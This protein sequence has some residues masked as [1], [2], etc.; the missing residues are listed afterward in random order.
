MQPADVVRK[1]IRIWTRA[2]IATVAVVGTARPAAAQGTLRPGDAV[3]VTVLN[4]PELSG[5]FPVSQDGVVL[6]PLLGSVRVTGRPLDEVVT[7]LRAG[8][9]REL[10]QP[11]F[12]IVPLVRVTVTG[13]AREPGVQLVDPTQ[14]LAEVLAM[15]GGAGPSAKRG[16]ADLVRDGERRRISIE[17]GSPDL[18]RHPLSG[19]ALFL[20]R[21]SWVSENL[22][23]LV[24][25]AATV[26]AAAV[27]SVILR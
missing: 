23:I 12:Q 13:E 3:R 7:E 4:E 11:D 19:D 10:A 25:A 18:S 9:T 5:D 22:G 8:Y 14:T 6:L 20:P 15:A 21:R 27:T 17:A 26:A 2:V 16:I 24:G 1:T